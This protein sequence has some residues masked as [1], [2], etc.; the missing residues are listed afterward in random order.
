MS[1]NLATK[2][3]IFTTEIIQLCQS[4]TTEIALKLQSE[5]V[6]R[7]SD[8]IIIPDSDLW[9]YDIFLNKIQRQR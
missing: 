1:S 4:D 8:L 5:I 2:L 9:N 6:S 3:Y 7:S